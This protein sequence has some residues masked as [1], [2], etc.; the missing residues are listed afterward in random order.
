MA[1]VNNR[2]RLQDMQSRILPG[3]YFGRSL[4]HVLDNG[5]MGECDKL[6]DE[7][8]DAFGCWRSELNRGFLAKVGRRIGTAVGLVDLESITP[9]HVYRDQYLRLAQQ[10]AN[11]CHPKR[12][13][14]AARVSV[15]AFD[16]PPVD[17]TAVDGIELPADLG[18]APVNGDVPVARIAEAG[19]GFQLEHAFI[20]LFAATG[21]GALV[22]IGASVVVGGAL[23]IGASS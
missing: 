20:L 2:D 19:S 21:V 3:H 17:D 10:Y 16:A 4:D 23:A 15:E 11:K 18:E 14:A 13:E 12:T 5:L 6:H 8:K 7:M 9:A 22:E 1:Y